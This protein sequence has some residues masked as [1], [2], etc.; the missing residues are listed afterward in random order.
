MWTPLSLLLLPE[1]SLPR[2]SCGLVTGD[3]AQ[4]ALGSGEPPWEGVT[5]PLRVPENSQHRDSEHALCNPEQ[6]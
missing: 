6:T 1:G 2:A 3:R 4:Q 5:S